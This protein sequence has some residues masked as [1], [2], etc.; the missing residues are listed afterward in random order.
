[1]NQILQAANN[2]ISSIIEDRRHLHRNPELSFQEHETCAYISKRLLSMNIEHSI[3]AQTGIVAHIGKGDRCIALRADIDALPIQEDTNLDFAS[4]KPGIMHA[5]G[6][7]AHTAMLLGAASILKECESTLNGVVK[8]IFQPGEEKVPGGASIMVAEGALEHPKPEAIFGQ[9]VYPDAPCGEIQISIGP[10]MASAD[11]IYITI[12]GKGAHAAQPH[13]GIDPILI[14]S[15]LI[16]HLQSLITKTRNPLLPGLLGITS[17][18][19]GSAT[20]IIPDSVEL[21]GTLRSFDPSWREQAIRMIQEHTGQLCALHG[22]TSEVTILRGYPA[23]HNHEGAARF[24]IQTAQR[25]I[26]DAQVTDFEPKM[27]GEDFAFYGQHIPAAFWMLGVRPHH[28]ASM[29]GLH[30]A[31]FTP[32]EQALPIGAAMMAKSA[33]DWL[34]NPIA[35][36]E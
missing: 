30:N 35:Y 20:N 27:W 3:I 33:I 2:R 32:D 25:L 8:L 29:P 19:G 1:M 22:A 10:T 28:Q 4:C 11:E 36:H 26:G 21:K 15:E 18:H 24:A 23:V 12:H 16:L 17:I 9:H 31:Q 13:Q 7:D 5:C 14:A 6:H 34:S